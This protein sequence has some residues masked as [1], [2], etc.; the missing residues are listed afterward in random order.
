M[1]KQESHFS[2]RYP[3]Q[4]AFLSILI[5]FLTGC[6]L[7]DHNNQPIGSTSIQTDSFATPA[8]KI[9]F[10]LE[11]NQAPLEGEQIFI[12]FLDEVTG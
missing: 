11:L 7:P 4:L 2:G 9:K 8:I 10:T 12:E 1:S 3:F 6:H 5:I